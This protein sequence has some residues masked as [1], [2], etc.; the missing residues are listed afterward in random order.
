MRHA[1][2]S[3]DNVFAT[4]RGQGIT[5]MGNGGPPP[6]LAR[7]DGVAWQRVPMPTGCSLEGLAAVMGGALAATGCGVQRF[8]DGKWTTE[9]G[10]SG[11]VR[12]VAAT[13]S[14]AWVAARDGGT[15]YAFANGVLTSIP[16]PDVGK[17]V[18]LVA[19]G[20]EV[21]A[22]PRASTFGGSIR[23]FVGNGWETVAPM[24]A[25]LAGSSWE[26]LLVADDAF[27]LASYH[28]S[29]VRRPR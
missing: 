23:R 25:S 6:G 16:G 5:T 9:A 13:P 3:I 24:P 19:A 26:G 12:A 27:V 4:V 11:W 20:E 17:T 18:R 21:F 8:A 29:I 1:A 22:Y 2:S 14:G 15:G 7:F 28:G 10:T